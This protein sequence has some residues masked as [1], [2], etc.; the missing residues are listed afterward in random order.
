M[1]QENSKFNS[2][3]Y[4]DGYFDENEARFQNGE[5]FHTEATVNSNAVNDGSIATKILA[6]WI[7]VSFFSLIIFAMIGATNILLIDIGQIFFA[8]GINAFLSARR[9]GMEQA[10]SLCVGL[11]CIVVGAGIAGYGL[12][13]IFGTAKMTDAIVR[14]VGAGICGLVGILS[15]AYAIRMMNYAR[16]WVTYSVMAKV[17]EISSRR[18]S[19]S[20]GRRGRVYAPIWEYEYMGQIIRQKEDFYTNRCK[21]RVGDT[22]M[23]KINPER[24]EEIE[25]GNGG[26]W[27]MIVFG[28]VFICFG[29]LMY[30]IS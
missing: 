4:E 5:Q 9:G 11:L 3:D 13:Q 28:I 8:F 22:A 19:S 16:K 6:I 27:F 26:N 10:K 30:F 20:H 12:I 17:V 14:K 23:I 21:Y 24:P 7:L 2:S 18:S 1:G 15:I 25:T 29:L